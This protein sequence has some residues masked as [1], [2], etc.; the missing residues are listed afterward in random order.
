MDSTIMN[1][2]GGTLGG[3]AA[4]YITNDYAVKMLF[5]KYGPI[6]GVVVKEREKFSKSIG[7]IVEK[8]LLNHH[9]IGN[10][11]KKDEFKR[12]LRLVIED[13]LRDS[14]PSKIDGM[15]LG[16]IN[17]FEVSE[18]KSK[19][20]IKSYL[21]TNI[22]K[23]ITELAKNI[24]LS[25]FVNDSQIETISE[26]LVEYSLEILRDKDLI[27]KFLR[28][29]Y[30]E[31]QNVQVKEILGKNFMSSFSDSFRKTNS[32]FH[33]E[34]KS[35]CNRDIDNLFQIIYKEFSFGEII[36]DLELKIKNKTLKDYLGEANIDE[37]SKTVVTTLKSFIDSSE[38]KKIIDGFSENIVIEL[39]TMD[40]S[41]YSFLEGGIGTESIEFLKP[42]IGEFLEKLINIVKGNKYQ[43][44][45]AIK[46]AISEAIRN[47]NGLQQKFLDF[48]KDRAYR[49]IIDNY[50]VMGKLINYFEENK[51][52]SSKQLSEEI[53]SKLENILREKNISE[54]IIQLERE[55]LFSVKGLSEI[56]YNNVKNYIN[57]MDSYSVSK[58]FDIKIGSVINI[59][60]KI[61]FEEKIFNQ[62]IDLIK[63]RYIYSNKFTTL[64]NTEICKTITEVNEKSL[65]DLLKID[66]IENMDSDLNSIVFEKLTLSKEKIKVQLS[67]YLKD[68]LN[69]KSLND[70]L[71]KEQ[72]NIIGD[73]LY[74]TIEKKIE[75]KSYGNINL[76]K[77]LEELNSRDNITEKISDFISETIEKNLEM[78]LK[79]NISNGIYRNLST[80]ED[81]EIQNMVENFMGKE[82]AP[83][84][85]FGAILGA[86]VGLGTPF[87]PQSNMA[88][89]ASVFAG[90]GVLTNVIAL[91]MIFKPYEP[92]FKI[93][94]YVHQGVI[95]KQKNSFAESMGKFVGEELLT[96]ESINNIFETKKDLIVNSTKNSLVNND[97]KILKSGLYNYSDK[98]VQMSGDILIGEIIKNKALITEAIIEEIKYLELSK[99][100]FSDV[101]VKIHESI[102]ESI[103]SSNF[104]ENKI[105]EFFG[106]EKPLED[107]IPNFIS[108]EII[109][110]ISSALEDKLNILID[111]FK[112][113]EKLKENI[114]KFS[115]KFE[116]IK[117]KKV[118]DF[119]SNSDIEI[120]KNKLFDF[121]YLQIQSPNFQLKIL[122]LINEKI[123]VELAPERKI[124]QIFNGELIRFIEKNSGNILDL[125]IEGS[126]RKLESTSYDIKDNLKSAIRDHLD[127]GKLGKFGGF[128][129]NIGASAAGTYE[130]ADDTVDVLIRNKIPEFLNSQKNSIHNN[131]KMTISNIG[132]ENVSNLGISV[133]KDKIEN[134]IKKIIENEK[135][136]SVAKSGA[137]YIF[138]KFSEKEF[139]FYLKSANI[140]SLSN[141]SVIFKD[142]IDYTINHFEKSIY[143]NR[144]NCFKLLASKIYLITERT[145]L[146]KSFK[147]YTS[148][149]SVDD[150]TYLSKNINK[151]IVSSLS[152]NRTIEMFIE[153]FIEEKISEKRSSDFINLNILEKDMFF[154]FESLNKNQVIVDFVKNEINNFI[155]NYIENLHDSVSIRTLE[156]GIEIFLE[157]FVNSFSKYSVQIIESIDFR[158]ITEEEIKQMDPR[159]IHKLF[160]SFAKDY[161]TKL[162]IYGVLG[163]VFGIHTYI[164]LPLMGLYGAGKV[165]KK[166]D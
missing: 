135:I 64:V 57:S 2:I 128:F 76:E 104:I 30:D 123:Q 165:I 46:D 140:K 113:P 44:E 133:S 86:V 52:V 114:N 150:L 24:E 162:K 138:D 158:K 18:N 78:I 110:L 70:F 58:M 54:I 48:F 121:M 27:V 37:L 83:I 9:T 31:N 99:I 102:S 95:S 29:L 154:Y 144:E 55:G 1:L 109:N 73:N 69:K 6:G 139:N 146:S 68:A 164:S 147:E 13:L 8:D 148:K 106:N 45:S 33:E 92:K 117:N 79:G 41:L 22:N 10:E 32:E 129:K 4:G 25:N 82:L 85:I 19:E 137:F 53:V 122:E 163:A 120:M 59:D 101:K 152:I 127:G 47:R 74:K 108:K 14:L 157:P 116:E 16:D 5:K 60:L 93:G 119:L 61:Y 112:T 131:L 38:G 84:N 26:K 156:H 63:E 28:D 12:N 49:E 23:S 103:K 72:K 130:V 89:N 105:K 39:K 166:V 77:K 134:S 126:L 155:V 43:L 107:V 141:L 71:N 115:E 111:E 75:L 153:I 15:Y 50:G 62:I 94:N 81:K 160:D 125:L 91:D 100:D 7:E 35:K 97:Y 87:I 80:L 98:I 66:T 17:D 40:S 51:S 34:L 149:I 159:E 21:K 136:K 151:T 36:S 96:K 124:N 20:T 67:K 11:L 3:A 118:S 132:K 142:E 143:M 90:I 88:I 145:I 56:I 65:K 42:F 161:F